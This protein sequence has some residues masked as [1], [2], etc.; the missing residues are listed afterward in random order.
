MSSTKRRKRRGER[1]DGRILVTLVIGMMDDGKPKRKYFY[2]RTRQEAEGKREAYKRM[3]EQGLSD[4]SETMTVDMWVEE[5]IARYKNEE[6]IREY[7]SCRNRL[8]KAIGYRLMRSIVESDL[9]SALFAVSGMSFSTVKRYRG[10][11]RQVFS[12]AFRNRI[13]THDPSDGLELPPYVKGSHRALEPWEMDAILAHWSENRA[14]IWALLMLL[15]GLRRSEMAAL[16]WSNVDM[17]NRQIRVCQA[18]NF[19]KNKITVKKRTK[20]PAGL[21]YVP[22]CDTLF[23]ALNTIP[24]ES[25]VGFVCL[26]SEGEP[27]SE[28]AI[29][30]GWKG[31][32]NALERILNGGEAVERGRRISREE[33]IEQARAEGKP[34]IEFHV[35]MH[36]LRH[37]FATALYD[38]GVSTKSAQY[39]LGH[40]DIKMTLDL[41]TH[42]SNERKR[43][44]TGLLLDYFDRFSGIKKEPDSGPM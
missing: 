35:K 31:F 38:A 44:D 33:R 11:I 21:R 5:W 42:L 1:R 13:I 3:R 37:T 19:K 2:G 20:T 26:S 18:A 30:R 8:S 41:Y 36:D 17:V 9:H 23:A 4:L 14:G 25:R 43:E 6:F 28:S 15:C 16:E 29:T 40:K 27:L 24:E 10:Y 32:N 12:A 7:R 22:I 39:F 34:F